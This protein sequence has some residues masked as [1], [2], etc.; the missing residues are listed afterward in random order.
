MRG[1]LGVFV[2]TCVC[3]CAG[4]DRPAVP[5]FDYEVVRAHE[6]EPHRIEF[7]LA[8]AKRGLSRLHL[9]LTVSPVGEVI[10][11]RATGRPEALSFWPQV[12]DEV[13]AWKFKPF[14]V[15]GKAV[16]AEI[17]E[18]IGSIPVERLPTIHVTPPAVQPNSSVVISLTTWGCIIACPI[19]TV[20]LSTK[21]I[22]FDGK[23]FVAAPGRHTA[24]VNPDDVRALAKRFVAA[25]FYSM[26]EKYEGVMYDVASY[27]LSIAIDGHTKKVIEAVDRLEGM[28]AVIT[29]LE[30]AVHSLAG[31]DRWIKGTAGRSAKRSS[32]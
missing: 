22:V 16:T 3:L 13:R 4:E 24:D 1:V 14:E 11:V 9:V 6:I 12:Q 8:G 18:D 25:D 29:E 7:P 28:P 10:D 5:T 15:D 17:E 2:F 30:H 26:D 21:G 32:Q 20:T 27:E 31:T 23:R 19:Y